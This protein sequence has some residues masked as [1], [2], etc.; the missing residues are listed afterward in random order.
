[1]ERVLVKNVFQGGVKGLEIVIGIVRHDVMR[2]G[3]R[4]KRKED[5]RRVRPN[6]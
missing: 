1:M 4:W 3:K 6:S 5:Q 2:E